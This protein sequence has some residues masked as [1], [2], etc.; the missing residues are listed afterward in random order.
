M[1]YIT[2]IVVVAMTGTLCAVVVRKQV[3]EIGLVV[4][5]VACCVIFTLCISGFSA[6][7]QLLQDMADMAGLLP[8]ILA[9]VVKSVGIAI[10]TKIVSELCRDAGEGGVASLVDMAGAVSALLVAVPLLRVV[11]A[12]ILELI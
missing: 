7:Y 5:L 8:E 1:E 12:M 11:M 6:V 9:P 3:V 4:S 2:Q 10:T